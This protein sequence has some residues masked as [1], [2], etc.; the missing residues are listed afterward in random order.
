M[1]RYTLPHL[2]DGGGT[3][4]NIASNAGLMGQAFSA[5]YCASKGGVV[6]LTR[7]LAVEY[8]DRGRAGELRR[9]RR[10]ADAAHEGLPP[11]RGRR[12]RRAAPGDVEARRRR[13]RRRSRSCVAY[14]ASD[15][16]RYMIGSIVSIDGG[17]VTYGGGFPKMSAASASP[18][19]VALGSD[20]AA[21]RRRPRRTRALRDRRARPCADVRR[22]P[23]RVPSARPPG[24]PHSGSGEGDVVSWQL[25]TWLESMVLV[26]ALAPARRG[27]EPD[28][29]D[30]PRAR[31][32]LHHQADRGEAAD[33]PVGVARLRLRGD[34]PWHRGRRRPASR[35]SCA[36]STLPEGDPATLGPP[37]PGAGEPVHAE[38]VRTDGP[39]RW[40]FYTSGTTADPKGARHTDK[41][42]GRVGARDGPRARDGCPRTATR[43]SS[44][45]RTSVGSAGCS[46]G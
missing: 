24:W 30:L 3:I 19:D 22:V 9:A 42:V 12:L 27:A 4:V 11:A 8:L 5:A 25:P 17:L 44:R 15:E 7:A 41:T 29:A 35:C 31:G 10:D 40:V 39:W 2:L 18:L 13:S 28:A 37:A 34:G 38:G 16:A 32:R 20:R 1:C 46:P 33:R 45:S 21:A 43:W 23:R 6:N 14:V 26:G 36:T